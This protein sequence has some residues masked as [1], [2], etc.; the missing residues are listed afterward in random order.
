V[1]PARICFVPGEFPP[2]W[3]GIARSALRT[4]R[5]LAELGHEVHVLADE[6]APPASRASSDADLDLGSSVFVHRSG[7]RT[8]SSLDGFTW[9]A[10]IDALDRACRFDVF[11]G[12]FLPAA[13]PCLWVAARGQRPVIASARG[14]DASTWLE[15]A[16]TRG[17][18]RAVLRGSRW[19]TT[20]SSECRERLDQ[21]E[22]IAH[23]CSSIPNAVELRH[24]T[25]RAEFLST[26]P[27]TALGKFQECKSIPTLVAA[28]ALLAPHARR[29]LR[30]IGDFVQASERANFERQVQD[31]GLE[32]DVTL[33]GFLDPNAA[34]EQLARAS[35]FVHC[36]LR[37]GMPNAVLEAAAHGLPIIATAVG[38]LRDVLRDGENALIVPP[39]SP[40]LVRAALERLASEPA[41]AERLSRGAIELARQ[42]SP[43]RERHN[44]AQ[45][46][47][48]VLHGPAGTDSMLRPSC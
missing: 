27:I 4:V 40:L 15:A 19:I 41:L 1:K 43:A 39:L 30:L 46:Y 12:F 33:T 11:H 14:A 25:W 16:D 34:L 21:L 48:G 13:F 32:A 44:W 8:G 17:V 35:I 9:A 45:V 28:Y 22:P 5:A 24:P 36:S 20:V 10:R 31:C 47:E 37:E 42:L 7:Q 29:G 23:K 3:G 6:V 18:V 2:Q 38:G 26:R